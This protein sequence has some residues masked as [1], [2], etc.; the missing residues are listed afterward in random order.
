MKKIPSIRICAA[1]IIVLAVAMTM[2]SCSNSTSNESASMKRFKT[3]GL[4]YEND[5]EFFTYFRFSDA[6]GIGLEQG[7]SRRDPTGVIKVGDLY[8]I[9]YTRPPTGIPVVGIEKANDTLRAFPWD[10]ADLWYASS[11]DG[12][13]WTEQGLAVTRGPEGSF[14]ARSVFTPDVLVANGRYYLFYQA[15]GSLS[16][17]LGG[18]D[19]T[20]NVIGMSWADSPDGPWTRHPEPVLETGP[21]RSID[22]ICVHDPTFI[23]RE[24]KYWLYYKGHPG[25]GPERSYYN[26]GRSKKWGIPISWCVAMADKP[27]GPFVKS[28]L[29]PV[30]VAGHE[31]V[32]FPYRQG[33]CALVTQ[34]PE[35][36]SIQFAEDGLNF[37]PVAHG[38]NMPHA[39]GVY[40]VGNFTD[41]DISPGPGITWGIS[42]ATGTI[43]G[44]RWNYLVR[45]DCDLSLEKGDRIRKKNK[46]LQEWLDEE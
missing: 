17:G 2:Q 39:A 41:T 19:F 37:Y 4:K 14:D 29:N 10:L 43:D 7:V 1:I 18:G 6:N 15:A 40:R 9:W 38:L 27:E 22:N 8:Y 16:Q 24:G 35:R 34:G 28:E 31:V 42:H 46:E 44:E 26:W 23:V 11:P 5:S 20:E 13:N 33:V 30:L 12:V 25:G 45:F 21:D 32:V 3:L 36:N